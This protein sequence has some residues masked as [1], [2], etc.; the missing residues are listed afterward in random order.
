MSNAFITLLMGAPHYL[1]GAIAMAHS[2]K[3]TETKYAIVCMITPDFHHY[4]T[5]LEII[6]DEVVVVP[7]LKYKTDFL[8]TKKQNDIYG[9]WKDVSYTK[10]QCLSLIKY[11][12]VCLLDA[13]LI[14]QQ[15]IDHL[16]DLQAPA[17]RWGNNWDCT[18][19]YYDNCRHGDIIPNIFI[20]KGLEMGYLVNGHCVVLEPSAVIYRKFINFMNSGNYKKLHKCLAMVDENALVKF[21]KQEKKQWTQ[22]APD[23]NCVPWKVDLKIGLIS[24]GNNSVLKEPNETQSQLATGINNALI[25][26]YFN[27][28]KAWQMTRGEWPDIKIWYN[29]WDSVCET[30]PV[31]T[32][33]LKKI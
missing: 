26:H 17:G 29:V 14:I 6:F 5:L 23:Y 20:N 32:E 18:V 12:K 25:L 19:N 8:K 3:K 33:K 21:M 10:W 30:Y 16:F 4:K 2:L 27:K 7:Y 9:D 1:Y 28:K 13:D 15:N 31:I 11:S 22:I 24:H